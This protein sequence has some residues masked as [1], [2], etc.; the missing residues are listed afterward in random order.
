MLAHK[1]REEIHFDYFCAHLACKAR[2]QVLVCC[3]CCCCCCIYEQSDERRK[4]LKAKNVASST[5]TTTNLHRIELYTC[6]K[7][8]RR[9]VDARTRESTNT[10]C[11]LNKRFFF[12]R[13][14]KI[15]ARLGKATSTQHW[16]Q[17]RERSFKSGASEP[18]G[19][20]MSVVALTHT[21]WLLDWGADKTRANLRNIESA[22]A[23]VPSQRC[24]FK[25][26]FVCNKDDDEEK[27]SKSYNTQRA[28]RIFYHLFD[29]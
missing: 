1:Q 11:P 23:A 29:F 7:R 27:K 10:L 25:C 14:P 8:A 16:E 28:T 6:N 26:S 9:L 22:A 3:C 2:A 20:Q 12:L 15:L 4:T 13:W 24:S 21:R 19:R 17:D 5:T 18:I